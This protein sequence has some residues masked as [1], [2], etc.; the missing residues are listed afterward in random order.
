MELCESESERASEEMSLSGSCEGAGASDSQMSLGTGEDE[1][2]LSEGSQMSLP[3]SS[4]SDVEAAGVA[5]GSGGARRVSGHPSG[6][7]CQSGGCAKVGSLPRFGCF[8][9]ARGV[10]TFPVPRLLQLPRLAIGLQQVAGADHRAGGR[11]HRSGLVRPGQEPILA[12]YGTLR[13]FRATHQATQVLTMRTRWELPS[14]LYFD[15]H[16]RMGRSAEQI[17]VLRCV[18]PA[19][20]EWLLGL[21]RGWTD[22]EPLHPAS[23][24]ASRASLSLHGEPGVS[25]SSPGSSSKN[26]RSLSLFSGCGA[27]DYALPWCQPV[28]YCENCPAAVSVLRAR[29]ADGSLP[30]APVFNDA[31]ALTKDTLPHS[32]DILVAG[33][34]CVDVCKA[35][36]KKSLEGSDSTLVFEVLRI[37][38]EMAV[39]MVFLEN[40]DNFRFMREFWEAVFRELSGLGFQIEWASLS[41]TH[42]G[43]PQ[44]RRRIFLLA[45]RDSAAAVPPAPAL[46]RGPSGVS[47]DALLP[48]L[49]RHQGLNFNSGRPPP[50]EW[51]MSRV[52]YQRN[53]HRLHMLGNAVIPLQAYLAARILSSPQ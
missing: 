44:R 1:P 15:P 12:V 39:P 41:A 53:R 49:L 17:N 5:A 45:R 8:S 46:P 27:L 52:E 25:A 34:P 10:V 2:Q 6:S 4:G 9:A 29:M 35:G 21:P 30:T 31:R 28:G 18:T 50:N 43:S 42:V 23:I 33:F 47:T 13:C 38:R 22:L 16:F 11:K 36:L 48:L 14:C 51:M 26:F 24:E 7:R 40:V 3:G 20:G 19:F 32:I 37:A